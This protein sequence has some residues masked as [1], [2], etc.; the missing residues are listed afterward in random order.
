MKSSILIAASAA[1]LAIASPVAMDMEKRKYETSWV[2]V[3]Y[4]VTVTGTET[5]AAA[6]PTPPFGSD[7]GQKQR[8]HDTTTSTQEAASTVSTPSP[9]P[10]VVVTVT[11]SGSAPEDSTTQTYEATPVSSDPETP[12]AT[13]AP[14][15]TEDPSD[16][17]DYT[18][19]AVS[20]HNMHR[21]NHSVPDVT[22][23]DKLAGYAA[24]TAST[25]VFAHD[26]D[27]GDKG[28]GQNLAAWG[29]SANA[30]DLG[31]VGALK[32]AITGFWYNGEF[33]KYL[34]E[35]YGPAGPDMSTF[36]EWGHFSQM[37]WKD[38]IEIG[39]VS[40]FCEAGTIYKIDSWFTVCN[41]AAQGNMGGAYPTNVLK[42]LGKSIL[43]V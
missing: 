12:S 15:D 9:P 35:Y 28:Y 7:G 41:Y 36:E 2:V 6:K 5:A 31:T 33:S 17:G 16:S 10:V 37:L 25:C 4:T 26:M 8:P 22:W 27:Q 39:C 11:A 3:E 38:S 43:T 32:M 42:P 24:N 21:S 40:Q 13:T 34:P 1:M 23:S 19:E 30:K 20:R 29:S 18:T 14:A